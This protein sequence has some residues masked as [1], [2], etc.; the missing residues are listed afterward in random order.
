MTEAAAVGGYSFAVFRYNPL[1]TRLPEGTRV[2][3]LSFLPCSAAL[4]LAAWAERYL[5]S[6]GKQMRS[7]QY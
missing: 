6:V 3:T 4:V 2:I 1:Q 7:I 5:L